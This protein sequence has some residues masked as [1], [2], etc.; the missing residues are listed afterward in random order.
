MWNCLVLFI[1]CNLIKIK[2]VKFYDLSDKVWER[3]RES[4]ERC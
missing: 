2:F 3:E 4:G 1:I